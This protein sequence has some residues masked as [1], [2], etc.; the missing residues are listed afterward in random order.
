MIW[1]RHKLTFS[2]RVRYMAWRL[3]KQRTELV[4]RLS[5]GPQIVIRPEPETDLSIAVEVFVFEMYKLHDRIGR[6]SVR[7]IVDVGG[8]VGF[9]M[10][11]WLTCCPNSKIE[12]YEPHPKHVELIKRH[13]ALNQAAESVTV[14][15]AA[16][17]TC[18]GEMLLTDDGCKSAQVYSETNN[19]IRV[20]TVDWVGRY[21]GQKID[22]L[23]IDIEGGEFAL[24][25][26]SRFGEI[27]AESIVM[28][29]HQREWPIDAKKWCRARL[30]ELG[31]EVFD[32]PI[33]A[34]AGLIWA[35]KAR[36]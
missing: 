23:K 11:Y 14:V 20:P 17:S 32:R 15:A 33:Q 7:R 29:W 18:D 22:L 13:I 25:K 26:D 5:D 6:N 36:N 19:V 21:A 10:C 34:D 8:N 30:E 28:E 27:D 24:L 16:A 31:Y 35:L 12:V 3:L 1:L 4:V 9:S 2:S